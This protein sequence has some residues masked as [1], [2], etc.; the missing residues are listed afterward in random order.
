MEISLDRILTDLE[1]V[2]QFNKTPQNGCTRFSYSKEDRMARDYLMTKMNELGMSIKVDG[3][4]NIRAKFC[5]GLQT[6]S[7]MIGSHIDTVENGGKYDGLIGVLA[8]LET[9]RVLKEEKV[10]LD[11]PIELIIFAEEEGSNFGVTMLGS[12]VLTGKLTLEQLKSIKNETGLSVYEV[13]KNFGLNVDA[14]EAEQISKNE[15][16]SMIELHI[17]QGAVLENEKKSIGIVQAIA[18][19]KTFKVTL[20]GDSNHAGTTPMNL[21]ADPMVGASKVIT[22]IQNA[23]KTLALPTTVATVGKIFCEPNMANVIPKKVEF[24]I[25]I[26]DVELEGIE[27]VVNHLTEIVRVATK[28]N[29]LKSHIEL[30]GKSNSV[31]LSSRIINLIVEAAIASD[32]NYM[33][34]NSGAVHDSAM[35]ADVTDVGMIFIPSIRGKSHSPEEFS[36][37]EDIKAGCNLL[38]KT[39][40]SLA[41]KKIYKY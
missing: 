27:A 26:R 34:M 17:E 37:L 7:I 10:E 20:E 15:V 5:E 39:V 36:T 8:A 28:E 35:M 4:G 2:I 31:K 18:G 40:K 14:V 19:M 29:S 41:S 30:I 25:D 12:K 1:N 6:P 38:L 16:D 33:K 3:I 9:I 23:A 21:R 32:S 24:F 13:C 11:Q 22:H